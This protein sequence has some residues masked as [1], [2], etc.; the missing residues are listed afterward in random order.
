MSGGTKN[1]VLVTRLSKQ[2]QDTRVILKKISEIW[3][4]ER[5]NIYVRRPHQ[6]DEGGRGVKRILLSDIYNRKT[7]NS[8]LLDS[9]MANNQGAPIVGRG[10]DTNLS[11]P[12]CDPILKELKGPTKDRSAYWRHFFKVDI[13]TS[14]WHNRWGY[15][16][17][18]Y[19]ATRIQHHL[20]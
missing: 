20:T 10:S 16:Q 11:R 12:I 6:S 5:Q 8:F 18:A 3:G 13:I 7:Q 14:T 4:E 17:K 9:T 1:N 19:N 2:F 15:I